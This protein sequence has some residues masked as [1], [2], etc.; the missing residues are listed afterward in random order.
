MSNVRPAKCG[1]SREEGAGGVKGSRLTHGVREVSNRGLSVRRVGLPSRHTELVGKRRTTPRERRSGGARDRAASTARS[2]QLEPSD[3]GEGSR[4]APGAERIPPATDATRNSSQCLKAGFTVPL[5]P[6]PGDVGTGEGL[7]K[8]PF[9]LGHQVNIRRNRGGEGRGGPTGWGR[10]RPVDEDLVVPHP[11]DEV[12][13]LFLGQG[14]LI[15]P[16][17]LAGIAEDQQLHSVAPTA[18]TAGPGLLLRA[19]FPLGFGAASARAVHDSVPGVQAAPL[20]RRADV[21]MPLPGL[22][23]Q[24][25]APHPGPNLNTAAIAGNKM[26]GAKLP[27]TGSPTSGERARQIRYPSEPFEPLENGLSSAFRVHRRHHGR[28]CREQ[29]RA[30]F[31][32]RF[33]RAAV[34]G[35][36]ESAAPDRASPAP[37]GSGRRA[38][39]VRAWN[40]S[41]ARLRG[42]APARCRWAGVS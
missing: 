39:E 1:R 40:G 38:E 16:E 20:L 29:G 23:P 5:P 30:H 15:V 36:G 12:L 2:R 42:A 7:Q 6:K 26:E 27:A 31:C 10:N 22:P 21:P 18:G 35:S 4:G 41:C 34:R 25:K 28:I 19:A 17:Q 37:G 8:L 13:S 24:S 11:G 33:S 32:R 9:S 14:P 3:K